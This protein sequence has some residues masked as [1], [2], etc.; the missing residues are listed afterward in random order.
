MSSHK[1]AY[2]VDLLSFSPEDLKKRAKRYAVWLLAR[3]EWGRK[4]LKDRLCHKG[5]PSELAEEVVAYLE[6]QN[7]QSDVRAA[8]SRARTK[9]ASR[10]NRA[11]SSELK[12]KGL[13]PLAVESALAE[14]PSELDRALKALSRFEGQA[15][16]QSTRAKAWRYLTYRGF[17]GSIISQAV[18]R[19]WDAQA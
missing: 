1:G 18:K 12:S 10:G 9:G 4:E 15:L 14:L 3:R 6:A 13:A 8:Q 17:T 2:S 16:D 19:F 7:L 11:I 5:Y